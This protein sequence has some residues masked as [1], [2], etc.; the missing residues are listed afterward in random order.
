MTMEE[1]EW[2]VRQ[3][4]A[5]CYHLAAKFGWTDLIY[6]HISA[7]IPEQEGV[8]LLNPF[9]VLFE[10]VTPQNL[11]K[12]DFSGKILDQP[13]AQ[14]NLAGYVVH[15]AVHQARPDVTCVLHTHTVSGIALSSLECG[16][17]PISQH[18]CRFYNRIGY[19]QYNGILFEQEAQP[20][21]VRDLAHHRALILRNHGLLTAGRTVAEAFVLMHYLE[22][23]AQAQ[24]QAMATQQKLIIPPPEVCEKTARQ[25][26]DDQTIAGALEWP[27]L[28]KQLS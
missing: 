9:G 10:H 6:T 2:R 24:L 13:E 12:V 5:H 17:L 7:R 1:K 19:H 22:R 25:F 4:L 15:S 16:L 28:L 27:A 3:E 20:R 21:L 11:V 23:A 26:G 14:I 18:A 8:L